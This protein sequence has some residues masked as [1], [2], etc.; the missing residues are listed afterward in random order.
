MDELMLQSWYQEMRDNWYFSHH[1]F[2]FSFFFLFFYSTGV[3]T[4]GLHLE[5]LYQLF[6]CDG[7]F[8]RLGLENYLPGLAWTLILQISAFWVAR[9]ISVWLSQQINKNF[10]CSCL[11]WNK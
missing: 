4:Q 10:Q 2:L 7:F 6:F 11:N 1:V 3:W 9:I 8:L 5:P